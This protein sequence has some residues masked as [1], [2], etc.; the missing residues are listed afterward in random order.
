MGRSAESDPQ[1]TEM[2]STPRCASLERRCSNWAT[3][4]ALSAAP[5]EAGEPCLPVWCRVKQS[6]WTPRSADSSRQRQPPPVQTGPA[7]DAD[8]TTLHLADAPVARAGWQIIHITLRSQYVDNAPQRELWWRWHRPTGCICGQRREGM[9]RVPPSM[10]CLPAP[11]AE[12][13]CRAHRESGPSPQRVAGR[14]RDTR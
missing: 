6:R 14:L 9:H 5:R 10:Q 7:N 11:W 12:A 8:V 3:L 1:Q 2:Q 4:R 13:P